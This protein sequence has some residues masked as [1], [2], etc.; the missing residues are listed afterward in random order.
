MRGFG[1]GLAPGLASNFIDQR[2]ICISTC[3]RS[4]LLQIEGAKH[5]KA[6]DYFIAG[7]FFP[8]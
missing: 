1:L 2:F 8:D 4:T 5:A 7:I 6:F 3:V